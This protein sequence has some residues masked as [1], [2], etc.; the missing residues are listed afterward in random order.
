M[1][2]PL[3]T[4]QETLGQSQGQEDPLK[5]G[6]A[7]HSSILASSIPWTEE[8]G[9]P[10]SMGSQRGRPN[11]VTNTHTHNLCSRVKKFYVSSFNRD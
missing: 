6:M 2:E 3:A 1:V 9:G 4:R 8:P 10:W 5:K 7:V 11:R